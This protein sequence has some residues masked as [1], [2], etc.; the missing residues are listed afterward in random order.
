MKSMV[1]EDEKAHNESYKPT[2][3]MQEEAI[4][5][6]AWRKEFKRGGTIIGVTR[7]NQLARRAN[8]SARTVRR[9]FAYFTRHV[10]DQKAEGFKP[11][12]KGYPS[13]GRIAWGLWGGDAG[14]SWSRKLH[15]RIKRHAEGK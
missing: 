8:L 4:R 10:N 6:L 14:F 7:A 9:M 3:G 1:E 15:G 11:G 5:S 2:A 12:E 13:A